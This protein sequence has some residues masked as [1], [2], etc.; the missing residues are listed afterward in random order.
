MLIATMDSMI[1][2]YGE[3]NYND[4]MHNFLD[5]LYHN[6]F[7][8]FGQTFG[9]GGIIYDSLVRFQNGHDVLDCGGKKFMDN[10]NGSLM[11]I[12]PISLYCINK[13][14]YIN[15]TCKIVS[16]ASSITHAHD[17]SK[18]SCFMFTEFL[19]RIVETNDKYEALNYIQNI[20]YE[21]TIIQAVNLGYDTDT[22]AGITGSIAGVMYGIENIPKRWLNKLKRKEY[23]E[24]LSEEFSKVISNSKNNKKK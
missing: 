3:I 9:V 17:I 13:N 23:L 16:E 21:D 14:L 8:S 19:R 2:N 7:T 20:N 5:W 12:L 15:E 4:I 6:E 11:R 24:Y 18:I 10:G 1:K 22:V